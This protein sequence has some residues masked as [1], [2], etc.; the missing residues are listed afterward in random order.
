MYRL[1]PWSE[2]MDL[3][4]FYS[5]ANASGFKNNSSQR[6]LVDSLNNETEKQVWILYYNNTPVGSVAAHSFDLMG[7]NCYRICA[8][9]CVFTDQLPF[10]SLRTLTGITTHQ[11]FTAQFFI[12]Q[13]IDWAPDDANLY[14]TS[15][16]LETGSQRL[17]HKIFCPA[18]EKT[19]ILTFCGNKEYRGVIQSIWQLH[20]DNFL[21]DLAKYKRWSLNV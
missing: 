17:V 18:L 14:I 3:T 4:E 19:G 13:C 1:I 2:S 5:K 11:N 16:E 20:V 7:K 9:T 8:R 12:P 15:N 10:T 6:L 21:E